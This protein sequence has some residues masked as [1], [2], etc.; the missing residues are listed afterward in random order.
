MPK[1]KRL[2]ALAA[3]AALCASPGIA[4]AA[5]FDGL[6]LNLT[7][8]AQIPTTGSD[9]GNVLL[10]PSSIGAVGA[11]WL[12]VPVSTG[13]AFSTTFSVNLTNV[14][15]VGNAD[16]VA[17][18]FQNV[19]TGALG[20]AGG[21]L[22]IDLPNNTTAGGAVA[23]ELQ[24]FWNTYGIVQNTDSNGDAFTN[25]QPVSG[26]IDLSTA[27]TITGTETVSYDP[28]THNIFQNIALNY[29]TSGGSGSFTRTANAIFDL[30]ARFGPT[31][32]VGLSASTGGGA[33]DQSITAWTVTSVPE[34]SEWTLL[35]TGLGIMGV[36]A[37]RRHR[38]A[39]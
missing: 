24:T 2:V 23:A 6:D 27:S 29:T 19:G 13:S 11:A 31:M 4:A 17:L 37:R 26:P 3:T 28:T 22:G 9:A 7:G 5:T 39:D 20:S 32:T 8:S 18:V 38:S 33:S 14:S 30:S 15:G 25:S 35:G 1:L 36:A 10:T 12:T 34:P 21:N 16:G